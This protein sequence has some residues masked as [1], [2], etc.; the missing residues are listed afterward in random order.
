MSRPTQPSRIA[1]TDVRSGQ[2]AGAVR[3]AW[4]AAT[5]LLSCANPSL[6]QTSAIGQRPVDLTNIATGTL[7]T[8]VLRWQARTPPT[9]F[10]RLARYVVQEGGYDEQLEF[11]RVALSRMIVEH[12]E[13][14]G[15]LGPGRQGRHLKRKNRRWA[16]AARSYLEQLRDYAELIEIADWVDIIVTPVGAVQLVA[17]G[18]PMVISPLNMTNPSRFENA[19]VDTFCQLR[20]CFFDRNI[21]RNAQLNAERKDARQ[22]VAAWSFSDA[23]Q[24]MYS[25]VDGLHFMFTDVSNRSHKARVCEAVAAELRALAKALTAAQRAGAK[26]DWGKLRVNTQARGDAQQVDYNDAGGHL[27]VYL[28]QLA[29]APDILAVAA[30]WL[31]AHAAGRIHAQH[32]P[33]AELFLKQLL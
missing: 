25:T 15:R 12:E 8:P 5:V 6:S 18:H 24:S 26:V 23:L 21:Q 14:L 3:T 4:V 19:I 11:A 7:A 1:A 29:M 2:L 31:K 32:F 13:F 30:P 17:D 10:K 22:Q 28:P 27:R 9:A 20:D 16:A 33:G